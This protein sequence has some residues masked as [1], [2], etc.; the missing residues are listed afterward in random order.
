VGK[1]QRKNASTQKISNIKGELLARNLV[2]TGND[3]DTGPTPTPL[4]FFSGKSFLI[5]IYEISS[6]KFYKS[7]GIKS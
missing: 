6:T 3:S 5:R 1:Y 4:Y 2:D 7:D